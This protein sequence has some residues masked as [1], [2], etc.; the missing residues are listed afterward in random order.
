VCGQAVRPD[1]S[2]DATSILGKTDGS[3]CL[4]IRAD[5]EGS[6]NSSG[7]GQGCPSYP[8]GCIMS[9]ALC[10]VLDGQAGKIAL[11]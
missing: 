7:P 4:T 8:L 9:K 6:E 11:S 2:L 5:P 3:S 10:F 1:F